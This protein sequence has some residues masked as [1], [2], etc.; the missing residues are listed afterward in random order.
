MPSPDVKPYVDL[1]L[2]DSDVQDIFEAA[3]ANLQAYL[4]DWEPR[5]GH[6]EVMLLETLALQVAESV[7]AINRVPGAVVEVLLRLYGIERDPG[8]PPVASLTFTVSDTTGHTIP[9][10]TR[11]AL[12]I[13]DDDTAIVFA[14]DEPLLVPPG[15]LTGTVT[16]TADINTT[17]A[18]GLS[19][20]L[21][22]DLLDSVVF[23]ES[24][25]LD[26]A[27]GGGTNVEDD[28]SWFQRGIQ[29]FS[30][31]SEA[32]VLPR[33]FVTAALER[34]GVAR[35][36]AIDNYDGTGAGEPGEDAGHITVAV[37]GEAGPLPAAEMEAMRVVMDSQAQA[38]LAVHVVAPTITVVNVAAT[39]VA[40]P[41]YTAE[42]VQTSVEL[43][44]AGYLSPAEW[45]WAGTIY[46]NELI[47]LLDRAEGVERV[48]A[49][50]TPSDDLALGGPAPLP[51]LG[52]VTVTVVP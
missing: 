14:T 5:E 21:G 20:V 45:L 34:P 19:D 22:I 43:A 15:Q 38:N 49:I 42:Q 50:A 4:P 13:A 46:V 35:A 16:G 39:V 33:H 44:L 27:V 32:L 11:V 47:A 41:G 25:A 51:Q 26:G 6:T 12:P 10:G 1:T 17:I 18:N 28:A 2:Y 36:V 31:L 3:L 40:V 9:A 29:R 48:V 23:V 30:R 52:D 24:V 8:S 7:F 37:Y